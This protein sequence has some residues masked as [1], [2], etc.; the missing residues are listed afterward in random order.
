MDRWELY[1]TWAMLVIIAMGISSVSRNLDKLRD[2][3]YQFRR[4]LL[5]PEELEQ[6]SAEDAGRMNSDD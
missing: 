2:E 4:D 3:L 1:V 5:D 6:L